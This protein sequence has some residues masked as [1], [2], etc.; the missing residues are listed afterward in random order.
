MAWGFQV[1]PSS[2]GNHEHYEQYIRFS[3]MGDQKSGLGVTHLFIQ[4]DEEKQELCGYITLRATAYIV[5]DGEQTRGF[6]ALEILE[7]A[8]AKDAERKGV[9]TTLVQ[10]AVW[11][12]S[13]MNKNFLGVRY[14]LLCADIQA[15]PFYEKLGFEKLADHGEVPR[16]GWNVDCVPMY[17]RLPEDE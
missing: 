1:N 3:A 12:A 11:L 15:V 7:L 2:C 4:E 8:V 14:V 6:P 16:D 5:H 13:S 17:L 10:Y 9:G